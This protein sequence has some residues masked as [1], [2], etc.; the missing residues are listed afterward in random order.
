MYIARPESSSWVLKSRRALELE[1]C[2][3]VWRPIALRQ[4]AYQLCHKAI[5][6]RGKGARAPCL[7]ASVVESLAVR[8]ARR[9]KS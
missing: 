9:H 2:G 5:Q 3:D 4:N 6:P 7:L 8:E 1:P